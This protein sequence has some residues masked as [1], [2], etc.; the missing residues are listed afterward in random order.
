MCGEQYCPSC[1]KKVKLAEHQCFIQ[2]DTAV[3]PFSPWF[4]V[5]RR[6]PKYHGRA[7]PLLV[8][9]DVEAMQTDQG[10]VPNLLVCLR[11]DSEVF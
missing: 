3:D 5:Y 4:K 2:V 1:H 8:F 9:F 6:H 10:H 7:D 11:H